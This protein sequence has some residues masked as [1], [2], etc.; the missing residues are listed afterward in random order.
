[1]PARTGWRILTV[2]WS[3]AQVSFHNT[4]LSSQQCKN[5]RRNCKSTHPHPLTACLKG[6]WPYGSPMGRSFYV[7]GSRTHWH[8]GDKIC[9]KGTNETVTGLNDDKRAGTLMGMGSSGYSLSLRLHEIDTCQVFRR[10]L[11]KY[12]SRVAF[13]CT[14]VQKHLRSS[15]FQ[16]IKRSYEPLH[17]PIQTENK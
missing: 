8:N 17:H 6:A 2:V 7:D 13:V 14:V 12:Q 10:Q 3:Y 15:V 4:L 5:V 1:M 16:N 9:S 11:G